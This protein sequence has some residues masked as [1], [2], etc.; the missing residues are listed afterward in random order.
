MGLVTVSYIHIGHQA[1][2]IRQIKFL[3]Q[4]V[5]KF[6]SGESQPDT[7]QSYGVGCQNDILSGAPASSSWFLTGV[8]ELAL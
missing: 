1:D 5:T 8:K 3:P 7:F 2:I 4:S 6:F